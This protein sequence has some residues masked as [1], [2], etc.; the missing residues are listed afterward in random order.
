MKKL[1]SF[2]TVALSATLIVT[3]CSSKSTK[4]NSTNKSNLKVVVVTDEGGQKIRVL[5]KVMLTH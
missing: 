2:A 4:D 1:F 3:S 5:T